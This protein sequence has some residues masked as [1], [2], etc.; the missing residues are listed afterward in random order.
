MSDQPAQPTGRRFRCEACGNDFVV[1]KGHRLPTKA[2]LKAK[3]E[4]LA[5]EDCAA[6]M[7]AYVS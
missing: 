4:A 2:E 7:K 5:C 3:D 1:P 6:E